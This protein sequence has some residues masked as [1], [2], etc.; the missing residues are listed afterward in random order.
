MSYK[1]AWHLCTAGVCAALVAM[2]SSGPAATTE[3]L[4]VQN[5]E[6]FEYDRIDGGSRVKQKNRIEITLVGDEQLRYSQ[7]LTTWDVRR[8]TNRDERLQDDYRLTSSG[9]ILGF[10][11][12][13]RTFGEFGRQQTQGH[14]THLWLPPAH[15]TAGALVPLKG[16]PAAVPIGA[17]THWGRWTVWPAQYGDHKFYFDARSGFL[18]GQEWQTQRWILTRSSIAGI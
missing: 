14:L 12:E 9:Y 15:R 3:R 11:D 8:P 7:T 18:V 13:H 4:P 2:C 1:P 17:Q 5:G 16:F 10:F 6:F